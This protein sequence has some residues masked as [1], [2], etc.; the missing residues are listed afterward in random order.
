MNLKEFIN[1]LDVIKS[2]FPSYK[3]MEE[4]SVLITTSESSIGGRAYTEVKN[5]F[6]GFDWENNQLRIE[7][8]DKLLKQPIRDI[9]K[10]SRL[11]TGGM[12]Y[13]GC[14]HC[15]R[16]VSKEDYYCRQCGRKLEST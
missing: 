11:E 10:I 16:K 14:S 3:N 4:I 2:V 8:V 1:H 15:G 5:I 6:M 12:L 7:P 9:S 13:W